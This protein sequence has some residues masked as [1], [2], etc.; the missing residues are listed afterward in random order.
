MLCSA[1]KHLGSGSRSSEKHSPAAR[2][3]PYF[4]R[5]LAASCVLYNRS[6]HSRG[7]FICF[8]NMVAQFVDFLLYDVIKIQ[9]AARGE[10]K[11]IF[12]SN[13]FVHLN[14]F[15]L[16]LTKVKFRLYFQQFNVNLL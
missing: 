11:V 5:V 14:F 10:V 4:F 16:L 7:F 15:H 8:K 13:V 1:V 9:M 6:E 3:P 2:V 12:I